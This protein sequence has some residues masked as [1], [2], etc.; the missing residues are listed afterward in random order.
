MKR[1]YHVFVDG[2]VQGVGFR[3]TCMMIAQ[4]LDL[5]G[6]V[7]NL[8]NGMVEIYV[9][10]END[11]IDKFL[12]RIQQGNRFIKVTDISCKEVPVVKGETHFRY[13]W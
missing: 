5:T 4:Q 10:G 9:Q 6:S 11:A 8:D 12:E 13:G 2:I 1:R 7:K 3:G